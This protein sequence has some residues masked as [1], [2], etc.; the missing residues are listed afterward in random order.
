[1]QD[2]VLQR[3]EP[4]QVLAVLGLPVSLS[5]ADH[6]SVAY[7]ADAQPR[8][9]HRLRQVTAQIFEGAV[10]PLAW[11]LRLDERARGA[12]HNEVPEGEAVFAPRA[13]L[14][15]YESRID[16]ATDRAARQAKN[17]LH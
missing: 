1:M 5:V 6:D 14:R 16:E 11:N 4:E 9:R 7:R 13:A 3:L 17:P 8:Q 2:A 15:L 12:Q 10:N